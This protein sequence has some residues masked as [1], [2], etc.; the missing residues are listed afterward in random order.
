LT[1][2][3][4]AAARFWTG[5]DGAVRLQ[6][7]AELT[8]QP[9]ELVAALYGY[10]ASPPGELTPGEA[11]ELIAAELL[12]LGLAGLRQRAVRV[13]AEMNAAGLENPGW[14]DHCR[15]LVDGTL[16]DQAAE[17]IHPALPGNLDGPE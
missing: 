1:P 10:A 7:E 13:A 15:L 16:A 2:E 9:E 11:G 17:A 5:E 14:L 3:D 12:M 4:Q 8:I 6:V